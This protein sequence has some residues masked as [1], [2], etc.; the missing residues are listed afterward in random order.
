[1]VN[2]MIKIT[3][4][5]DTFLPK[6]GGA[7]VAVAELSNALTGLDVDVSIIASQTTSKHNINSD[8]SD[9]VSC[10]QIHHVK[11]IR[12]LPF[13]PL[14]QAILKTRFDTDLIHAH[15]L[16]PSGFA[17]L[18]YK[19]CLHKPC[20]VT[21][22]GKDIQVDRSIGYG[23]RL[24]WR[25]DLIIK[26]VLKNVDALIAPSK[27]VA[28]EAIK[29]GA[30]PTKVHVIP[31]GVNISRFN[32]S[33]KGEP[34]R[35]RLK[36]HPGENVVLTISRFHPKKGYTHLVEAIPLVIEEFPEVKFVLCGKGPE[37][38]T[39]VDMVKSLDLSKNVVF[40]GFVDENEKP[41]YYA[42]ADVFVIPSILETGPVTILEALASSKPVVASRTGN[43][44]EVVRDK[45]SGTLVE[46]TDATQLAQAIITYLKDPQLRKSAGQAGRE[47]IVKN[48]S[49]K[50]VSEKTLA[51]YESL[52]KTSL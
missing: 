42:A 41:M 11:Q 21:M 25:L 4:I 30:D 45:V 31:N 52:T 8:L 16:Y 48:Y 3:M 29:A 17:G 34:I 9:L 13:L 7:E 27:L 2:R 32:P 49:W 1:M 14:A 6:M 39:I 5:T 46:P 38:Q 28:E 20:I 40:A 24:D 36:I 44:A 35:K 23:M 19:Y 47:D 33:I 51:L 18:I 15:F 37:R 43:I 12:L 10:I 26:F 50:T 22:H